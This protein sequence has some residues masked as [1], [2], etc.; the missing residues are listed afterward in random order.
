MGVARKTLSTGRNYTTGRKHFDRHV[1]AF[2]DGFLR[3]GAK[4]S[5]GKNT[6]SGNRGGED[7]L[8]RRPDPLADCT[9]G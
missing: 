7:M 3:G 5:A 2:D 1:I 4:G 6:S 9:I 8:L